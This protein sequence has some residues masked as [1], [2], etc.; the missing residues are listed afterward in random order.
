MRDREEF[1]SDREFVVFRTIRMGG[2]D[3]TPGQEFPKQLVNTRK[4]RQLFEM[5]LIKM[6]A[7]REPVYQSPTARFD[8]MTLEELQDW[9]TSHGQV[10]RSTWDRGQLLEKAAA[11]GN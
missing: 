9:L 5:S 6:S 11:L 4:L 2:T 7:P 3:Y 10:P 8:A 1:D